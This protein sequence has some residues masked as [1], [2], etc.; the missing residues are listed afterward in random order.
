MTIFEN[1]FCFL[2]FRWDK[3]RS[4]IAFKWITKC[5]SVTPFVVLQD[6]QR[7]AR[8]MQM[9]RNWGIE[10]SN[11]PQKITNNTKTG[12]IIRRMGCYSRDNFMS[13]ISIKWEMILITHNYQNIMSLI[14]ITQLLRLITHNYHNFKNKK[15]FHI[16]FN[17]KNDSPSTMVL[18]FW[19]KK[20]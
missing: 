1:R 14:S 20:P 7:T 17:D 6:T 10:F 4:K 12:L 18:K 15:W 9:L 5:P 13:L 11:D 8:E 16:N 19:E 2:V 3:I